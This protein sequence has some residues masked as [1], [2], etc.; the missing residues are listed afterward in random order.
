MAKYYGR[1]GFATLDETAPGVWEEVLSERYYSGDLTRNTRRLVTSS[2]V[3]DDINISNLISIVSDPYA[4]G[5]YFEMRY[6]EWQGAK[7]K[8][9]NVDASQYPRLILTVGGLYNE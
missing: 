3:N 1:I 2:D 4:M 8:I 5:H 7:W 9:T 6:A